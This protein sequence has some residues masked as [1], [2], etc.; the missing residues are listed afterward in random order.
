MTL[1]HIPG[2][3]AILQRFRDVLRTPG[4]LC[5]ADLDPEDGSFH[6]EGF[7]GHLGFDRAELSDKARA[8]GFTSVRFVTACEMKKEAA[9]TMRMFPIF[10]MVAQR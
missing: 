4:Y 8:A 1:H 2:H 10:L 7:D 6:G 3:A 9:G 5:I